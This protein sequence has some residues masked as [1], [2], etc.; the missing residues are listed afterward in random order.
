MRG[1]F[2]TKLILAVFTAGILTFSMPAG[3]QDDRAN[4]TAMKMPPSTSPHGTG[5]A[6]PAPAQTTPVPTKANAVPPPPGRRAA[7]TPADTMTITGNLSKVESFGTLDNA[8]SGGLGSDM[9]DGSSRPQVTGLIRSLP[10]TTSFRTANALIRRVLLTAADTTML[11][12]NGSLAPGQDLLTLR[13]K[14]LTEMGAVDDAAALYKENRLPPHDAA[15]AAAGII[16]LLADAQPSLAC[17]DTKAFDDHFGGTAEW[18]ALD[19]FCNYLIGKISGHG[20]V[21]SGGGDI[22]RQMS[23]DGGYRYRLSSLRDLDK[24]SVYDRA[25]LTADHRIT[26]AGAG[27]SAAG[28]SPLTLAMIEH[29]VSAPLT[30]RFNALI[31]GARTGIFDESDIANFYRAIPFTNL[32]INGAQVAGGPSGWQRVAWLYKSADTQHGLI[33]KAVLSAVLPLRGAYGDFPLLPFA[34]MLKTVEPAGFGADAVRGGVIVALKAG[35]SVPQSWGNA[36]NATESGHAG[37]VHAAIAYNL[38]GNPGSHTSTSLYS[39]I[40]ALPK[41][42]ATLL[43]AA[44]QELDRSKKLHNINGAED[45]DITKPSDAMLGDL[46]SAE[47]DHRLGEVVLLASIVLN[48]RNSDNLP[49]DLFRSALEGYRIVG[50]NKEARALA[51]EVA[52]DLK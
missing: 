11:S 38:S 9:W 3:A 24:L 10:D 21:A 48:D 47:N 15:M 26:Y 35:D 17:L 4:A 45:A 23:G 18:A 5:P 25:I 49:P 30:L 16:A 42:Q 44:L 27:D 6:A 43:A 52:L 37:D 12:D 40:N 46:K 33:D 7:P 31:A 41:Q 50:L 19:A 29:D 13:I 22:L 20:H 8:K 39:Q 1:K 34:A 2:S 32:A 14:K 51:V 36:W 28:L